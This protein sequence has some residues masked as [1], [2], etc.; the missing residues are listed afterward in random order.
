ML[1]RDHSNRGLFLGRLSTQSTQKS[2]A[3]HSLWTTFTPLHLRSQSTISS[4]EPVER[5]FVGRDPES[6]NNLLITF[7]WEKAFGSLTKLSVAPAEARSRW[8]RG[9]VDN[10]PIACVSPI[11]RRSQ[12]H[13]R[14]SD[15]PG[16]LWGKWHSEGFIS[17]LF[18]KSCFFCLMF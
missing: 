1:A 16:S 13:P 3:L 14:L 2:A 7:H 5:S 11:N 12:I 15:V 10:P 18:L 4:I 9:L 6:K 8:G 17:T